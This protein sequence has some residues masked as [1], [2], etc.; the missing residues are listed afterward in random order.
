MYKV[1]TA[2]MTTSFISIV[3]SLL[4]LFGATGCKENAATP[5]T[6]E[7]QQELKVSYEMPVGWER[8]HEDAYYNHATKEGQIPFAKLEF[9]E[10]RAG[11]DAVAKDLI[12]S[13]YKWE[14][15]Q[16]K[17]P[18]CKDE[19]LTIKFKTVNVK[20][21]NIYV[22]VD[23]TLLGGATRSNVLAFSKNGTVFE[24]IM[25]GDE[26]ETYTA[27]LEKLIQTVKLSAEE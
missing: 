2:T 25:Y 20:G 11:N 12:Y 17:N 24:F 21:T 10:Y 22:N 6:Q 19:D 14:Q 9:G 16:C 26:I 1:K 4:C 5:P 13:L 23:E 18:H 8:R 7:V 27:E 3:L 15:E